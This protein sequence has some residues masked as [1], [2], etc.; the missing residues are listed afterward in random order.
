LKFLERYENEAELEDLLSLSLCLRQKTVCGTLSSIWA[1]KRLGKGSQILLE[2][3]AF[4]DPDCIQEGIFQ[5]NPSNDPD[6]SI[7][8]KISAYSAT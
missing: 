1:I 6:A 8:N 4:I 7:P 3:L 5:N 2:I